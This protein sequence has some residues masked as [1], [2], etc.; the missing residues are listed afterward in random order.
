MTTA[1]NDDLEGSMNAPVGLPSTLAAVM[2]TSLVSELAMAI[3]GGDS[4]FAARDWARMLADRSPA[5]AVAFGGSIIPLTV[6]YRL[7]PAIPLRVRR[8]IRRLHARRLRPQFAS[9]WPI[10]EASARP[11]ERWPGWPANKRFA[12]VL[13]HDVEGRGGLERCRRLAEMEMS[14]GFRSSFNFIPEGEYSI[15][16]RLRAFLVERGF[17]VAIHD[18][19][20]DGTLYRSRETFRTDAQR[21]NQ[22][23]TLWGAVGFR[24]GFM[25]HNLAWIHDLNILYDASTFDTDPFEPQTDGVNTIFPFW[26]P[27]R[28]GGGY[29]ELPYTLPQDST[30][31]LV[32]QERAIDVWKAKLD[33]VAAHGGLALVIVHP[34]YMSFDGTR[35]SSEY[36][37]ELYG[38][39]LKY[40][41]ARYRSECWFAL[42]RDV[43]KYIALHK[44]TLP[45]M[46]IASPGV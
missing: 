14:L 17:E 27:R 28:D 18:L 10:N 1:M 32:F 11:P 45:E 41:V 29:V 8:A 22:Y 9:S 44:P 15:P 39:L 4:L 46:A 25:F 30:L 23:L 21:I 42:P 24:S 19:R 5:D 12:F 20:H 36:R 26:V 38:E 31:F 37:A 33:W 13:T 3:I 43:A 6:Y 2:T 40:V 34:D 7:K 16:E 35:R